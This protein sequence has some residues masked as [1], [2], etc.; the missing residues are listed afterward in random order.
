MFPLV[1]PADKYGNVYYEAW[2]E[3]PKLCNLQ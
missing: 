3:N 1:I 2:T